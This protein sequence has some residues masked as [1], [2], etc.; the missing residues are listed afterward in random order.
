MSSKIPDC[1]KKADELQVINVDNKLFVPKSIQD[2]S[3][4]KINSSNL[5]KFKIVKVAAKNNFFY[6]PSFSEDNMHKMW[7]LIKWL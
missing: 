1:E 2:S 7:H 6:L 5:N 4:N 3:N